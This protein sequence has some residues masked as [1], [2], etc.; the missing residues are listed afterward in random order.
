MSKDPFD[1]DDDSR[2]DDDD[3]IIG[4]SGETLLEQLLN[5]RPAIMGIPADS[6]NVFDML[7]DVGSFMHDA[8]G[9]SGMYAMIC[10]IE[11]NTG[12]S[13]EI[14]GSKN[15][16]EQLLYDRYGL[17]DNE[18]WLKARNSPYWDMMIRE[19]Y[20]VSA[21]WQDVI[22]SAIAGQKQPLSIRMKYA[23]RILTR[24]F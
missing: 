2:S 21:S 3:F 12:W 7:S 1:S 15:D 11:A 14:V 22:T 10:A 8:Y 24:R 4:D 6:T 18:A 13:L 17:F 16:I 23:W 20:N 19:I 5:A 9:T